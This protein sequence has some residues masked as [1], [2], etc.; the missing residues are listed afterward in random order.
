M[1]FGCHR[2]W[3]NNSFSKCRLDYIG[4]GWRHLGDFVATVRNL[5]VPNERKFIENLLLYL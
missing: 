2:F 3:R 1:T 5:Q 4:I